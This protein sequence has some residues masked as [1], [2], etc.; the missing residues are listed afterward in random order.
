MRITKIREIS[1]GLPSTM[2]NAV[3][4]FSKMTLS[5]VAVVTDA[6]RDGHPIVGFGFNSNGRYSQGGV[7]RERLIPRLLEAETDSLLDDVGALD[8]FRVQ[9]CM[10]QNEKPGGHGERAFAVGALDA[11]IC[12]KVYGSSTIGG[13]KSTVNIN[14]ISSVILNTAASSFVSDPISRS[15]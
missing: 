4:D 11:A 8:P 12:P 5:V 10:M 7:L 13:K 3:I 14:A 15:G 1:A 2:R 6:K 9:A